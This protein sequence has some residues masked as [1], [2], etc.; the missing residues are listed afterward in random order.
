M[1]VPESPKDLGVKTPLD[2]INYDVGDT[3]WIPVSMIRGE[4]FR[5]YKITIEERASIG[6]YEEYHALDSWEED[7]NTTI[8]SPVKNHKNAEG[9]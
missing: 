3:I 4:K 1:D 7:E 8:Q 6:G 9:K 5:A 2:L